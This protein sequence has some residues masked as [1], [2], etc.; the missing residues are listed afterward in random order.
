M[1]P[2]MPERAPDGPEALIEKSL[3]SAGVAIAEPTHAHRPAPVEF[4][5]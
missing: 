3:L 2:M 4:G 1:K 5:P